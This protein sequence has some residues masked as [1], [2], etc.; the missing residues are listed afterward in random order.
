MRDKRIICCIA[1][2]CLWPGTSLGFKYVTP[3]GESA[4]THEGD[5]FMCRLSHNIKSFGTGRFV[6]EAGEKQQMVLEGDGYQYGKGE[7]SVVSNPPSWRPDGKKKVLASIK[8]VNGEI[9]VA[10]DLA[11]A[12]LTALTQGHLVGFKGVLKETNNEPMDVYLSAVGIKKAYEDY[13]R[14]EVKLLSSNYNQ[15]KRSRIQYPS[16]KFKIPPSGKILLDRL[17]EYLLEDDSVQQVFVDGHTDATGLN[18]DN[19]TISEKRAAEV[20]N[21]LLSCGI[22]SEKI[23]TR[24]HGERY[25]VVK[26]DSAKHKAKNRRTTIRLSREKIIASTQNP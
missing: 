13:K 10:G 21:Y 7:V 8:A 3:L 12:L 15:L 4:W 17:V 20:T 18:K 9:V 5:K 22:P 24:F 16:G 23:V 2:L 19:V 6:H 25:P 11:K 26:N 1:I 14:C